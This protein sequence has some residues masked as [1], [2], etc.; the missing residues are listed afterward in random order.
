[1]GDSYFLT[2]AFPA[3]YGNAISGRDGYAAAEEPLSKKSKVSYE[4]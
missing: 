1:M 2:G 4:R 3:E